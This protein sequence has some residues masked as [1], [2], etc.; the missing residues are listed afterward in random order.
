MA[1]RSSLLLAVVLLGL[2]WPAPLPAQDAA[3][4]AARRA[5]DCGAPRE[6][7]ARVLAAMVEGRLSRDHGALLLEPLAQACAE[8][9]P[10]GP[11]AEKI[12]EG[13]AKSVP[14]PAVRRVLDRRLEDLRF[15]RALL[16]N[17]GGGNPDPAVVATLAGS[18]EAGLDR[19]DL[20]GL[21]DR[22][23]QAPPDM[24]GTAS[25]VWAF[26]REA[27]L[28]APDAAAVADRGLERKTLGPDW[29]QFPR[30]AARALGRGQDAQAVRNAALAA[31]D[32]G[33]DIRVA[34]ARLK[35]TARDLDGRAPGDG[36]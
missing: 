16:L 35:L 28:S 8:Q 11:L 4:E 23:P 22:H 19:A 5:V 12:D 20:E 30:L 29:L 10:G 9:L 15:T 13:L 6:T 18:L 25:L 33:G 32:S 2:L 26:L 14:A 36:R 17:R 31:L 27:G 34:A 21:L 3:S 24:L 1:K 7:V